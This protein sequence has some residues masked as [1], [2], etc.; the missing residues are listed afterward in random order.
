M[1]VEIFSIAL[2]KV[3]SDCASTYVNFS[4]SNLILVEG[5][6]PP[7]LNSFDTYFNVTEGSLLL[8]PINDY[9]LVGKFF[10]L[11]TI[12]LFTWL[13][14][15]YFAVCITIEW[16]IRLF[17]VVHLASSLTVTLFLRGRLMFQLAPFFNL[18]RGI[19]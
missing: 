2:K 12:V 3:A 14:G 8:I 6:E 4:P 9:G 18:I 13:D 19:L 10:Y 15:I 16:L 7:F 17:V 1:F 5:I 11:L